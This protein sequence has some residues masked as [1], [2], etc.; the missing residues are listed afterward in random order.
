VNS[1]I[2]VKTAMIIFASALPFGIG[3]LAYTVRNSEQDLVAKIKPLAFAWT[4]LIP[5]ALLASFLETRWL[6]VIFMFITLVG[7]GLILPSIFM[8][9]I[10]AIVAQTT[11]EQSETPNPTPQ[12][13]NLPA[14][15]Q[16][17]STREV[18]KL[19]ELS[20]DEKLKK[21]IEHNRRK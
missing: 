17:P 16:P 6:A 13:N 4:M 15:V 20:T 14:T 10:M 7:I 8:M 21:I 2:E 11:P 1:P 12:P 18:A 9:V 19:G 5:C 3:W